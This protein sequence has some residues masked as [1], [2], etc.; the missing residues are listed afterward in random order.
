MA[1]IPSVPP[2]FQV[3]SQL[4]PQSVTF[5]IPS[6]TY[7]LPGTCW[8]ITGEIN[9]LSPTPLAIETG[10]AHNLLNFGSLPSLGFFSVQNLAVI[11]FIV[12]IVID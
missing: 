5:A 11:G 7:G 6:G 9:S 2:T 4:A 1:P 10:A 8:S 3:A 12:D